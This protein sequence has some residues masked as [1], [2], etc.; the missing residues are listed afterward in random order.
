MQGIARG[1]MHRLHHELLLVSMQCKR[2][3]R[4]A[5]HDLPK[6]GCIDAVRRANGMRHNSVWTRYKPV[7]D[8]E[9]SQSATSN[10]SNLYTL[11]VFLNIQDRHQS[12]LD[13]VGMRND[14]ARFV[15]D[16]MCF[17]GVKLKLGM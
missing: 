13:K 12:V 15:Q 11:L 2:Q 14:F 9:P 3:H 17:Q 1:E 10:H 7:N 8:R 4:T 16:L 5:G 6:I